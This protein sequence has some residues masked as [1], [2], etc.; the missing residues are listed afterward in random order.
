MKTLG[1]FIWFIKQNML[2]ATK[3]PWIAANNRTNVT[4]IQI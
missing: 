1:R 2:I 4:D 3:N